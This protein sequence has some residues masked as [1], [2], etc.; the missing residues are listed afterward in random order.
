MRDWPTWDAAA[1]I[2]S[3]PSTNA[4]DVALLKG[5]LPVLAIKKNV[6]LAPWADAVYGCDLPW[7]E[8]VQGLPKF[9]G[10]RMAYAPKACERFGC[11]QV[12]I[13]DHATSNALRFDEIGSV[14]GGGNSAF[15]ALNLALQ[16]GAKRVLLL[17]VDCHARAGVHWYGRNVARGMHNPSETNFRRWRVAFDGAAQTLKDRGVEVINTS[18]LSDLKGFRRMSVAEALEK[19]GMT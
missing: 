14:G 5:R 7:W 19:W 16:F 15:Q 1:I 3:G 9:G 4:A 10:L 13:P 6:E 17:G 12:L 11:R 2:A 8:S 18:P